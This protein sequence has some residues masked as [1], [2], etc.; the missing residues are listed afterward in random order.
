M[1][2]HISRPPNLF[3]P[4]QEKMELSG[5]PCDSYVSHQGPIVMGHPALTAV[6]VVRAQLAQLV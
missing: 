6:H 3:E 4:P 1:G 5:V 2:E